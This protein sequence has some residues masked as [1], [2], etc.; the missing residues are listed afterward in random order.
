MRINRLFG[1]HKR[2]DIYIV[3]TGPTSRLIPKSFFNRKI[4]IGLNKAYLSFDLTYC[5]TVHPE[6]EIEYRGLLA[7]KKC[8]PVK[9]IVKRKSPV[10]AKGVKLPHLMLALE[11][12]RR[13]VFNTSPDWKDFI[14]TN[15]D[16]LFIGHG[17]QQTAIDL[18]IR[19]GA[20][21]VI[22]VGVD[23][24]DLGGDHHCTDQHVRFSGLS[25]ADVYEE[26]RVCAYKAR[27]LAREKASITVLSMS[28]LLGYG[29][30]IH[31]RD[32]V[33]LRQELKLVPFKVPID[34]S[35]YIR[36]EEQIKK[37][38]SMARRYDILAAAVNS[39]AGA[40][41][42]NKPYRIVDIGV[43]DAN[44]GAGMVSLAKKLGRTNIE[45]YGFDLFEDVTVNV[46]GLE[47]GNKALAMPREAART[48][49]IASGAVKVQLIK[50]DTKFTI[51]QACGGTGIAV[52]VHIDGGASV[53]TIASDFSNILK[54][55]NETTFIIIN[56]YIP[57]VYDR[58]SAFILSSA[59]LLKREYG[60]DI[61]VLGDHDS[62][63]MDP[64]SG[65]PISVG[66]LRA[67]CAAQLTPAKLE[68]LMYALLAE[69]FLKVELEIPEAIPE[70]TFVDPVP[71]AISV[72]EVRVPAPEAFQPKDSCHNTD[73][74]PV[75]VC[76]NICGVVPGEHCE[77]PSDNCGRREPGV[78]SADVGEIPQEQVSFAQVPEERQEP[79][80][81]VEQ[82]DTDSAGEQVPSDNSSKLGCEIPEGVEPGAF[83]SVRRRRRNSRANHEQ[84]G[85]PEQTERKETD[86]GV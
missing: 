70:A 22:L 61:T 73:V 12:A 33:N 80:A 75:R 3:G 30:D 58:G 21:N 52:I 78:G 5:I 6:L 19:M 42:L 79:N 10:D 36:S 11:D 27:K 13:Y 25:S 67:I 41:K 65:G 60:I 77:L 47:Y 34:T 29:G 45:Y 56:N 20:A 51:A 15:P 43:Y 40:S 63:A 62:V 86:T 71:E 54:V 59:D 39:T 84:P 37:E 48:R 9:W 16:V 4:S 68:D 69:T 31:R 26:Y 64:Y 85:T 38:L 35:W 72:E 17:V 7:K 8:N 82:G 83:R 57:D 24:G 50:G 14:G 46:N 44:R 55:C 1:K 74:Q 32:Y 23:M 53:E 66:C 28:P 18:A 49:L 2:G 81:V 76:K